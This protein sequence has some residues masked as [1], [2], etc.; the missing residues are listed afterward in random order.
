MTGQKLRARHQRSEALDAAAK[1]TLI[2]RGI[3]ILLFGLLVVC[4]RQ[5]LAQEP[6]PRND[7]G[8]FVI[9]PAENPSPS[10]RF[11]AWRID[12]ETGDVDFC[13]YDSGGSGAGGV[14]AESLRCIPENQPAKPRSK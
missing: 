12:T 3:Y 4:A 6:Q 10:G 11:A 9:V 8:K 13:L 5:G 2:S 14:T 7:V 1:A